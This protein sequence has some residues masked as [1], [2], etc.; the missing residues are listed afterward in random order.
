MTAIN[1]VVALKGIMCYNK[2]CG[3]PPSKSKDFF[4]SLL[5]TVCGKKTVANYPASAE[6]LA[7]VF[8]PC[9]KFFLKG[10]RYMDILSLLG[11]LAD[12]FSAVFAV[13]L[14]LKSFKKEK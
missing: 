13:Y 9:G 4:T 8:G 14:Y 5:S 11:D 10:G 12:I 3:K 2:K 1:F 6:Y 7:Y